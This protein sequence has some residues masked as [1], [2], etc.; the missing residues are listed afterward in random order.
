[1]AEDSVLNAT[2]VQRHDVTEQ[3]AIIKVQPDAGAVPE[4]EAG[5]FINLALPAV[6]RG[7]S[8]DSPARATARVPLTRRS[9]SIASPPSVRD[10]V[11]LF[12]VLVEQG[13][14]TPRLWDIPEGGRVWMD[15]TC[16]GSFTLDGVERDKNLVMVATGT[17]IAPYV[18]MLRQYQNT[19]RWRSV[20]VIH[21][22]R[23]AA[24]L[25]YREE[26]EALARRDDTVRYLP[27][28][29]REPE[30]SAWRGPRGRVTTTLGSL[31]LD[32]RDTHVFLCG[33]PA[34]IDDARKLLEPR[35]FVADD[36]DKPGNLHFERYW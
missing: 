18:S 8:R 20:T 2:I 33:N 5:Q 35:G 15:D 13:R 24:D 6:G 32:P 22:V 34:M 23:Y 30:G 31:E 26:L 10:H 27:I 11:E 16:A 19:R 36:R 29:S 3:L 9:Y 7:P 14:L 21:G 28:A 1:M 12:L 25:G 17:G 4:F